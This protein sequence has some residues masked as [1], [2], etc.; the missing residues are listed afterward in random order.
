[1]VDAGYSRKRLI[2]VNPFNE[3]ETLAAFQTLHAAN[4]ALPLSLYFDT[5]ERVSK[6]RLFLKNDR[7]QLE[8]LKSE[9]L[10]FDAE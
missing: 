6:G 3:E 1:M 9:I 2:R 7:Q 5:D 4:P 10:F 8:L